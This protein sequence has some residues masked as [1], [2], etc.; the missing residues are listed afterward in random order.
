VSSLSLT[1][2]NVEYFLKNQKTYPYEPARYVNA[3]G[4]KYITYKIFNKDT[5]MLERKRDYSI[6]SFYGKPELKH[7]KEKFITEINDL[8]LTGR[9]YIT[10]EDET[11]LAEVN[12]EPVMS[13]RAAFDHVTKLKESTTRDKSAEA[14]RYCK[15]L[16]FDF[17]TAKYPTLLET[18]IDDLKHRH[19]IR[20]F[21][22][23]KMEAIPKRRKKPDQVGYANYTVNNQ[24]TYLITLINDLVASEKMLVSPFDEKKK[25]NGRSKSRLLPVDEMKNVA[26]ADN[27]IK[28]IK[29]VFETS[30]RYLQLSFFF[31]WMYYSFARPK[32]LRTL[33]IKHINFE[34]KTGHVPAN[35]SKNRVSRNFE[36]LPP[37]WEIIEQMELSKYDTEFFIFGRG[38]APGPIACTKRTFNVPFRAVLKSLNIP[39]EYTLYS[40][41]HYG[42]TKHFLAGYDLRWLQDQAGFKTLE[43]LLKY[44]RSLGLSVNRKTDTIPPKI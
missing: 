30:L 37:L 21:E 9:A 15:N 10:S 12:L 40:T 44:L 5:S 3:A 1:Q 6:N 23:L 8:L 13:L 33:K 41:K 29:S 28:A 20:Y 36:I 25:T 17:L 4:K 16:F 11:I 31:H 35:I 24:K 14:Y 43:T 42:V 38:G 34:L 39:A 18:S 19:L 26:F 2:A 7:F 27:H 32:E 22:W